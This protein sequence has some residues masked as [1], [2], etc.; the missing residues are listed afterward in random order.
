MTCNWR[1]IKKTIR[2]YNCIFDG[3]GKAMPFEDTYNR[4]KCC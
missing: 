1:S 3:C 2:Y 4:S